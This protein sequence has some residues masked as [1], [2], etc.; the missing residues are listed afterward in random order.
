MRLVGLADETTLGAVGAEGLDE[1]KDNAAELLAEGR[2]A[3]AFVK[4]VED[5]G[6]KLAESLP[7]SR[8]I[9]PDELDNHVLFFHPRP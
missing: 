8:E 5:A 3:D 9:N 6:A 1:L 4:V 2:F 7:A